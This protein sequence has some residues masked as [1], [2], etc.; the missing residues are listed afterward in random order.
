[1]ICEYCGGEADGYAFGINHHPMPLSKAKWGQTLCIAQEL[2]LN[3]C[4]AYLNTAAGVWDHAICG[5][6]GRW[7]HDVRACARAAFE[8]EVDLISGRNVDAMHLLGLD[9][10]TSKQAVMKWMVTYDALA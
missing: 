5:C 1:M 7:K 4:I 10:L 9:G 2:P 3:H 6:D 8:S